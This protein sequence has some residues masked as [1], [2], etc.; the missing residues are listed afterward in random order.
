MDKNIVYVFGNDASGKSVL[1]RMLDGHPELAVTPYHDKL[2]SIARSIDQI[3]YDEVTGE[4][5]DIEKFQKHNLSQTAYHRLQAFHHGRPTRIA[6]TTKGIQID[7]LEDFNYYKFEEAWVNNIIQNDNISVEALIKEIF[8]TFFQHW[9]AYPYNPDKCRYFVGM[10]KSSVT[11]IMNT[12]N[13]FDNS[14]LIFIER[15]PRGCVGTKGKRSTNPVGTYDRIKRGEI[16]KSSEINKKARE[17]S[18]KHPNRVHIITFKDLI[19]QAD[20]CVDTALEFLELGDHPAVS[21]PTYCGD[22][23]EGYR[24]KYLGQIV[25]DWESLLSTKEKSLAELQLGL[26]P[27]NKTDLR[28]YLTHYRIFLQILLKKHIKKLGTQIYNKI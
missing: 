28:V 2:T 8:E 27:S 9:D 25:D 16:Y 6:E 20:N 7:L 21:E 1:M 18:K 10:G 24:D 19:T 13:Q 26:T 5:L 14:K 4:F 15:D 3:T 12:L 11:D 23:I 17:L 22:E